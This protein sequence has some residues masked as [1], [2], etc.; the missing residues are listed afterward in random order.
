MRNDEMGDSLDMS[1]RLL[2]HAFD[3]VDLFPL[4][5]PLP[6]QREFDFKLFKRI[7]GVKGSSISMMVTPPADAF[8]GRKR[9]RHWEQLEEAV[10]RGKF[11][12]TKVILLDPDK[13]IHRSKRN[14]KVV[15]VNEVAWLISKLRKRVLAIYHH[16]YADNLSYSAAINLFQTYPRFGYDFGA[17]AILFLQAPGGQTVFRKV[18]R[19]VCSTLKPSRMF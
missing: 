9:S 8:W 10:L 3:G 2:L 1:K 13:G 14:N 7:F 4:I 17:A 15:H 16:A 6:S 5:C 12:S 18:K 11:A 19:I